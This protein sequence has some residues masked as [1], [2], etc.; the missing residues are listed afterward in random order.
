[1]KLSS[2]SPFALRTEVAGQ[3]TACLS[4]EVTGLVIRRS[5]DTLRMRVTARRP[6]GANESAACAVRVS[7]FV[8]ISSAIHVQ[9]RQIVPLPTAV[10][11]MAGFLSLWSLA[12]AIPW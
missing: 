12:G 3:E 9:D 11:L 7:G 1:M 10:V 6:L 8:V 2:G 5:A 4:H